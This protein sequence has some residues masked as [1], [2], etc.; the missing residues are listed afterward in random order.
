MNYKCFCENIILIGLKK[1]SAMSFVDDIYGE[2]LTTLSGSDD[3]DDS[4]EE[5]SQFDIGSSQSSVI[6]DVELLDSGPSQL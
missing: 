1:F 3:D 2:T 4:D 6:E 5:S